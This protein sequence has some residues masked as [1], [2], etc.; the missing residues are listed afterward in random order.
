[1]TDTETATPTQP[2]TGTP[3]S[4]TADPPPQPMMEQ[5]ATPPPMP[6][7]GAQPTVTYGPQVEPTRIAPDIPIKDHQSWGAG[8]YHGVLNALGGANEISMKRNLE[9]GEMEVTAVKSGPGQQ[10]KR[11]IS[12]ALA[13]YGAAAATKGTG[14]GAISRGAGAGVQAGFKQANDQYQQKR[15]E[16][17]EDFE[18]QQK[19]ATSNAQ[20][21]LLNHQISASV[22]GLGRAKV[23]AAYGDSDRENQFAS[24]IRSGGEGTQDLG[25]HPTFQDAVQTAKNMPSIH[26]EQA[27]GNVIG[28]PHVSV[29]KDGVS[30]VD[31]MHYA[32]VTPTWLN[33]MT[34]KDTTLWVIKPPTKPGEKPSV[35]A[36]TIQA[37]SMT[38]EKWITT[39][40]ANAAAV[41]K[42]YADQAEADRKQTETENQTRTSKAGAAESYAKADEAKAKATELNAL[43]GEGAGGM[44]LVDGIGQGRMAGERLSYL[45]TKHP[46]IMEA[47][48]QKYPDFDAA[49]LPAYAQAEKEFNSTKSGAGYALNAGGTALTHLQNLVKLNTR[50][51][52]IF[53]TDDYTA[54][55]NQ[56]DTTAPEL[57]KFYGDTTIPAIASIKKTLGA[58]LPGNRE[59]AIKTQ[60][61]SMVTK[62]GSYVQQWRNAAPS[63]AYEA[64]MPGIS[65]DAMTALKALDPHYNESDVAALEG[66]R[67]VV[68]APPP[69]AA[70]LTP[71]RQAGVTPG[72]PW[73]TDAQGR[74]NVV[75]DGKWTPVQ[76]VRQ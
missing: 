75:R 38:N 46:E 21:A 58:T 47:V 30:H 16:A 3:P 24:M 35:E 34:D 68:N 44:S 73:M 60:A 28:M 63:K 41:V 71:T 40:Q 67:A 65:Q 69:S 45:M 15:N 12:G 13:G 39:Q 42:M 37:G 25:I 20:R 76:P 11:I 59:A 29:D 52:H 74:V 70:T 66:L 36:Q 23:E 51:S 14:P 22:Y 6:A 1:M 64:K 18:T 27:Q 5:P 49:K 50:K 48:L 19:T 9:T 43:S 54:Y 57:A 4:P 62:F 8:V 26:G 55:M 53:G 32:L 17:N 31:G 61:H 2:M 33:K 7:A 72:E 56:L 10:W